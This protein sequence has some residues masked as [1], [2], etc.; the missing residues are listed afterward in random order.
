MKAIGPTIPSMYLDKQMSD[1]RE[2]GLNMYKPM[3]RACSEWLNRQQP[4]SVIY[5][6]F[7]SLAELDDRQMEELA[8][9]LKLT[10]MHFLWVV[11]APGQSM[12]PEGFVEE[13]S[14]RGLI[15]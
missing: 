11:R 8:L 14:D 10:N 2:Y 3:A 15:V 7:G 1:D 5:V 13:T 6:A 4:A 12:I 9:G